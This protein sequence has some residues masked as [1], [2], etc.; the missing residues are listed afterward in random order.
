MKQIVFIFL[1][2]MITLSGCGAKASP[3]PTLAPLPTYTFQPTFTVPPTQTPWVI[4]VTSTASPTPLFTPTNTI[5]PTATKPPTNTPDPNREPKSY[6]SY[7]VGIDIAP[8]AWRSSGGGAGCYWEFKNKIG[9]LL[10]NNFG[11]HNE[12]IYIYPQ[13]YQVS[14]HEECGTWTWLSP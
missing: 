9:D 1:I 11:G 10:N 13:V 12:T 14:F 3:Y 7:L 8:G 4:V 6:G 5:P 2:G